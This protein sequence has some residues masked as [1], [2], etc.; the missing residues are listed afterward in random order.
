MKHSKPIGS[1]GACSFFLSSYLFLTFISEDLTRHLQ[2]LSLKPEKL[3]V[4]PSPSFGR[5]APPSTSSSL[6][7]D[8]SAFSS[9]DVADVDGW[10]K[11]ELICIDPNSQ[12]HHIGSLLLA[13]A[14]AFAV[15]QVHIPFLKNFYL[16]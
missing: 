7:S 4:V 3:I 14:L 13:A 12:H 5:R 15:V 1:V 2:S 10:I 9:S 6:A 8:H 11:I 16:N